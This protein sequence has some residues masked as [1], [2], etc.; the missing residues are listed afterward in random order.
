M[1]LDFTDEQHELRDAVRKWVD[2]AYDLPR[3]RAIEHDRTGTQR[4]RE[5]DG[6]AEGQHS[7]AKH[8]WR[9]PPAENG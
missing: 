2:R 1:N 9:V 3:R 4:D 7:S 5:N 8:R 6:A